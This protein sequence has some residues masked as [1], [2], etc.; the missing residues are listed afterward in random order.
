[1]AVVLGKEVCVSI[2][3]DGTEEQEIRA[4]FPAHDDPKTIR[5][6]RKL[7]A[8]TF[9]ARS[10]ARL[11][12]KMHEARVDFFDAQ[13]LRVEGVVFENEKGELVPLT[14]DISDWQDRLSPAWKA[15]FASYFEERT[16]LSATDAG[17]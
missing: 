9:T 1:M 11:L 2:S 5:A 10:N 13:C 3:L 16:A 7:K 17:N 4:Y 6:I 14:P 8:A 12:E 15:S